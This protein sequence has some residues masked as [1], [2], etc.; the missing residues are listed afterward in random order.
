MLCDSQKAASWT[1]N[2]RPFRNGT[3]CALAELASMGVN[4]AAAGLRQMLGETILLSVPSVAIIPREAAAQFVEESNAPKLI[5]GR[6]DR[7]YRYRQ[8]ARTAGSAP[9]MSG[10]AKSEN[11]V[12]VNPAAEQ[13]NRL[14]SHF[15]RAQPARSAN[16]MSADIIYSF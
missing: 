5:A 4:C 11:N 2:D 8:V 15:R 9:L 16:L 7:H 10:V 13:S 3:G 14:R 12:D 6:C 1:L